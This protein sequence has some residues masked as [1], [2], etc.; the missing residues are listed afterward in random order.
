MV[1]GLTLDLVAPGEQ[2][3]A[4][5]LLTGEDDVTATGVA[6]SMCDTSPYT[7]SIPAT[8]GGVCLCGILVVE[9]VPQ[10]GPPPSGT[11]LTPP[12]GSPITLYGP[13]RMQAVSLPGYTGAERSIP[14]PGDR[15]AFDATNYPKE[16]SADLHEETYLVHMDPDASEG[17]AMVMGA[18]GKYVATDIATQAELDTHEGTPDAH[19]DPVTLGAGNDAQMATLST[20]VL[21]VTLKDHDHSGD[22]GDGGQ[23]ELAAQ[24]STGA[25]ANQVAT[26]DGADGVSWQ[27]PQAVGEYRQFVY[28]PD[29][30]GSFSF[31]TNGDGMPVFA[32]LELE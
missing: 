28:A 9:E 5:G 14:V 32:L 21:T 22:A 13:G 26:A 8:C 25:A 11:V 20:Q 4:I 7:D 1:V 3:H 12:G 23:I 27:T 29:G 15:A 18:D 17:E 2:Y 6:G 30:L 16:H 24:K 19:H 10:A 31:V